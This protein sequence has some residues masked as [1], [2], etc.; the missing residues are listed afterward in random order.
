VGGI[1]WPCKFSWAVDL[2]VGRRAELS[3]LPA[4]SYYVFSESLHAVGCMTPHLTIY[5]YCQQSYLYC[6]TFDSQLNFY[7]LS[8]NVF[9]LL[10][11]TNLKHFL[12]IFLKDL[13]AALTREHMIARSQQANIPRQLKLQM[14]AIFSYNEERED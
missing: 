3:S 9:I 5:F 12:E 14:K 13:S 7:E 11:Q 2:D 8:Y 1:S 10:S 4:G 6:I